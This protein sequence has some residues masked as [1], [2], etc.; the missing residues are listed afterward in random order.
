V[1]LQRYSSDFSPQ[2]EVL[3]LIF[4]EAPHYDVHHIDRGLLL[5]PWSFWTDLRGIIFMEPLLHGFGS[6]DGN[7]WFGGISLLLGWMI[8]LVA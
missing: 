4:Y 6:F 5:D 2:L 1:P 7:L 3:H 8:V